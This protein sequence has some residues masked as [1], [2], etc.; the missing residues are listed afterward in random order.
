MSVFGYFVAGLNIIAAG[1]FLYLAA[2]DYSVRQAWAYTLYRYELAQNGMPVDKTETDEHGQ[3]K[4]LNMSDAL[5]AE[6]AG[7]ENILTQEDALEARR[8]EI[9][10][11]IDDSNIKSSLGD[12]RVAG[13][14]VPKYVE[15]LLPLARNARE[16]EYL[17]VQLPQKDPAK[18]AQQFNEH[19]DRAKGQKDRDEK[20]RAIS[21]L[22]VALVDV[23]PTEDEKNQ[24]RAEANK[25]PA[26]RSDPTAN[27]TYQR[28]LNIVG[29]EAAAA[30]AD[31]QA[32]VLID[33]A[34]EV[35]VDRDWARFRFADAHDGRLRGLEDLDKDFLIAKDQLEE[36]QAAAKRAEE[37]ADAQKKLH[38]KYVAL[39][40]EQQ[41]KT[42]ELLT[43]LA[44]IQ[45]ELFIVRVEL[46][47]ANRKN[48][49]L[50]Q[51]IRSSERKATKP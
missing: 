51:Q 22:L 30:A 14:K 18:F 20:R 38:D 17:Y 15:V 32:H 45:E 44:R 3:P 7:D 27:P 34:A 47:D 6:L 48:Q 11:K 10:A 33:M 5:R 36:K 43:R 42:A 4:Y 39:L 21:Q 12:P 37:L 13:E 25:P 8:R 26:Q 31:E 46:R 16:R 29:T 1:A 40:A 49:E 19:F 41:D 35:K 24:R 9:Q 2:M 50:E 28:M 23:L